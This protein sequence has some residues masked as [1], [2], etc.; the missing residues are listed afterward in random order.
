MYLEIKFAGTKSIVYCFSYNKLRI[1]NP[2]LI[3]V[4]R[5]SYIV[6]FLY[7]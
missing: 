6:Y 1:I 5:L 2:D 7:I 3:I 4:Y